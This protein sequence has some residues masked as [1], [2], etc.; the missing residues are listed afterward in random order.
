[1]KPVT[2]IAENH[3]TITKKIFDEG[4]HAAEFQSHKK[5]RMLLVAILSFIFF[6][7]VI[8]LWNAGSS[9]I[10]PFSEL[11]FLTALTLWL[12]VLLPKTKHKNKYQAMTRGMDSVPSRITCFY[13]DHMSITDDFENVTHISYEDI[14]GWLETKNLYIINCTEK[15]NVLLSKTGFI[16]GDFEIL[17]TYF[18]K[19]LKTTST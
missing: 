4:M 14:T 16:S 9:R 11:V 19:V 1:M 8:W 15:R 18:P 12:F 7:L 10:L 13:E 2:K 3:I 5:E 6:I 17:K